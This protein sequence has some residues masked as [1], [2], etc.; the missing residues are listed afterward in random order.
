VLLMLRC[1][2]LEVIMPKVET[3]PSTAYPRPSS[4]LSLMS[5]WVQQ[6]VESFFAT[7]RLLIDL[8]MRQN[9]AAMKT[10]RD[11]LTDR[12]HSPVAIV[13]ELAV[14]G[15]ANFVEAQRILLDMAQ[16][17]NEIIMTGVKERV[18]GFATAV[19]ATEGMRRTIDTFIEMQQDFL[20][21]ASKQTQSWLK[22]VQAG[23][24]YE[25]S[26]MIEMARQAMDNFVR[27]QKKFL[28]VVSEETNKTLSGKYETAASTM[29]K[30]EMSKLAREAANALLD[31]QKRLLDVAGQQMKA[32]L[33]AANQTMEM[34]K[35]LGRIPIANLTGE[36]VR[37]FVDAEKALI[38]NMVM[39][40]LEKTAKAAT[41]TKTTTTRTVRRR[42][43]RKRV[44]K[45]AGAGA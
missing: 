2:N 40:P 4:F 21:I 27:A 28:D 16:Q 15:T 10:L 25:G 45:A 39:K 12:E 23:K 42:V 26:H 31:A 29:K 8:A 6:G 17:E 35:P 32:N 19:G 36:G 44:V 33:H 7:Q 22:E 3:G 14:E 34:L 43:R 9:S 41:P 37:S 11:A 30:T 1:S 13:T 24:G 18:S 38:D 20:T 5:G